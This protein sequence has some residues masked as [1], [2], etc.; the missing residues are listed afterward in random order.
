MEILL[1]KIWVFWFLPASAV[2]EMFSFPSTE[3]GTGVL[4]MVFLGGK[5][6]DGG[7]KL[8]ILRKGSL[9]LGGANGGFFSAAVF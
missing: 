4:E 6:D 5:A 1:G 8:E 7:M 2:V 3:D 9:D